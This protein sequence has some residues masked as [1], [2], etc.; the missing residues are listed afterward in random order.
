MEVTLSY[1]YNWV[2]FEIINECSLIKKKL[3]LWVLYKVII[4]L[5]MLDRFEEFTISIVVY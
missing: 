3:S 2:F 5:G 1:Y 4:E